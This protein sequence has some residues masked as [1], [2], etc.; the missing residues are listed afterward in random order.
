M[1]QQ[2]VNRNFTT[3]F[4]GDIVRDGPRRAKVGRCV[5]FTG[6]ASGNKIVDQGNVVSRAFGYV[7][8]IGD[9]GTPNTSQPTHAL[10]AYTV[11]QGGNNFFGVFGHRMHHTLLGTQAGGTLAASL[12][13]PMGTEIECFDMVTGMV[14]ELFNDTAAALDVKFGWGLAYVRADADATALAALQTASKMMVPAGGLIAV[15]PGATLDDTVV[16]A[17]PNARIVEAVSLGAPTTTASASA[18]AIVQLTQ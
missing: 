13:V 11:V 4:Q 8:E 1:F 3:G 9:L 15:A 17:I 16:V 18:M 2:T 7:G 10:D 14:V 6:T 5:P 12:A